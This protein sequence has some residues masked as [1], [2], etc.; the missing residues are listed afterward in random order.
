LGTGV[1]VP[2]SVNLLLVAACLGVLAPL[3]EKMERPMSRPTTKISMSSARKSNII[4]G[5]MFNKSAPLMANDMSRIP[6]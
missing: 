2:E 3:E 6:I 5:F 4:S 1:K